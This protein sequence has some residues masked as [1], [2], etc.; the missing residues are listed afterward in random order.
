M[1]ASVFRDDYAKGYD[2]L[3]QEKDYRAEV[4]LIESA[5]GLAGRSKNLLD[6]GCGTGGHAIEL[7]RRG[8]T[9]TG[10]DLSAQMLASARRKAEVEL[11]AASRPQ[12]HEGD[13]R[14]F[15]VGLS[16]ATFDAAVMMFAVIG[17]LER[18]EDV[19][20]ALRRVRTHLKTGGLFLCDFWWGP[21]VLTQRPGE[22]VRVVDDAGDKLLRATRTELDTLRNT[23]DVH[24]DLFR[25]SADRGTV[26][27]RETHRMRYF[28]GPE[29]ELL[30][31]EAGLRM[32]RLCQFMRLDAAPTDDSWNAMLVARAI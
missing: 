4:D 27:A 28:F 5:L 8:H 32:E 17:Y 7:A 10:V 12:F 15:T 24:F 11:P 16:E 25:F 30:L 23:A 20:S 1:T 19:V 21:A 2:A 26:Q 13:A 6:V 14:S 9:V 18:N 29:L 3:Y 31:S 22:R